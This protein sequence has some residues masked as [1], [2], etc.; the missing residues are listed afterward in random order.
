VKVRIGMLKQRQVELKKLHKLN[1]EESYAQQTRVTY[2]RLRDT[3]ERAVEEALL[4]GVVWRFKA[5]VS[6]QSLREVAVEDADYT[7]I[8]E[9]MS[10]CSRFAHDGAA[11][12]QVSIP[13]PDDVMKDISALEAW[14]VGTI[15]R[16]ETLKKNRPKYGT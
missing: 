13:G 3:W 7:T 12:A 8:Q 9:N 14:F 16:R 2:Q 15:N 6:T 11:G 1:E 5:G 10:K 4:N